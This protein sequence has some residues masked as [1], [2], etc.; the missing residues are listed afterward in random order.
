MEKNYIIKIDDKDQVIDLS[1]LTSYF[2]YNIK[3]ELNTVFKKYYLFISQYSDKYE[4]YILDVINFLV[5]NKEI[6]KLEYLSNKIN[7]DNV[8]KDKILEEKDIIIRYNDLIEMINFNSNDAKIG[9]VLYYI[10]IYIFKIVQYNYGNINKINYIYYILFNI[11]TTKK[12][13]DYEKYYMVLFI[14]S[15]IKSQI[16]IFSSIYDKI[17]KHDISNLTYYNLFINLNS[18]QLNMKILEKVFRDIGKLEKDIKDSKH[19]KTNNNNGK[20]RKTAIKENLNIYFYYII[21]VI[22]SD[23]KYDK[24]KYETEH[25]LSQEEEIILKNVYK[26]FQLIKYNSIVFTDI[27]RMILYNNDLEKKVN[28]LI[29]EVQYMLLHYKDF[30]EQYKKNIYIVS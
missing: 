1:F 30:A 22:Y 29:S 8:Q 11:K 20:R 17:T 13:V 26:R 15:L 19:I 14:F 28:F 3:H 27:Y 24:N 23:D 12:F 2:L 18:D 10:I 7:K 9:D 4:K 6:S 16:E 5:Q 25:K 21:K